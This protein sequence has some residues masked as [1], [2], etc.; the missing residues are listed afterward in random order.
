MISRFSYDPAQAEHIGGRQGTLK[1]L[2]SP[3]QAVMLDPWENDDCA[4]AVGV[5]FTQGPI[6]LDSWTGIPANMTH[7][8]QGNGGKNMVR[9]LHDPVAGLIYYRRPIDIERQSIWNKN[10]EFRISANQW[11]DNEEM[12]KWWQQHYPGIYWFKLIKEVTDDSPNK[13]RTKFIVEAGDEQNA[14]QKLQKV[15]S[16]GYC[17]ILSF[18]SK[19]YGSYKSDEA[20]QDAFV[21]T[22]EYYQ[23]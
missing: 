10:H 8:Y 6:S 12:N 13:L 7:I 23:T 15:I 18:G 5:A 14:E 1:N 9:V 19:L 22:N 16:E 3:K 2:W 20:A 21:P 4:R 17:G 11:W